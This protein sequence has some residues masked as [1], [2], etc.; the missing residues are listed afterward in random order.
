MPRVLFSCGSRETQT[1]ETHVQM[2]TCHPGY[3]PLYCD[4]VMAE[5]QHLLGI[6]HFLCSLA[7]II[8]PS[9]GA[10]ICQRKCFLLCCDGLMVNSNITVASVVSSPTAWYPWPLRQKLALSPA[11]GD[12]GIQGHVA[13]PKW[14]LSSS[15]GGGSWSPHKGKRTISNERTG[16]RKSSPASVLSQTPA[17]FSFF[18]LFLHKGKNNLPGDVGLRVRTL[19]DLTLLL[20]YSVIDL[21]YIL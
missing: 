15:L 16:C 20:F 11:G 2:V 21:G 4:G 5:G 13:S 18:P 9:C 8:K 7:E 19:V 1:W 10:V 12:P 3:G 17:L 14:S 6:L